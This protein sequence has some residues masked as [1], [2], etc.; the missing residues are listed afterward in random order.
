MTYIFTEK[1]YCVLH[2]SQFIEYAEFSGTFPAFYLKVF[3][4]A[5]YI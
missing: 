5:Q 2:F 4:W 1:K 3:G